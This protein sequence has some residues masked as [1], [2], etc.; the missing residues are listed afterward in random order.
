MLL[1][2]DPMTTHAVEVMIVRLWECACM[3]DLTF[4]YTREVP[5]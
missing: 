3:C 4:I 5:S 2:V 1:N